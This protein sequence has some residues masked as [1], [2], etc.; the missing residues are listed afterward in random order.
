W[1][2]CGRR[3]FCDL[4]LRVLDVLVGD[5][6][7]RDRLLQP[8]IGLRRLHQRRFLGRRGGGG[9]RGWGG[10]RRRLLCRSRGA[11][12]YTDPSNSPHGA[13][14]PV[15]PYRSSSRTTSSSS[16]VDTSATSVST[17][18]SI[19][20]MSRG[21]MWNASPARSINSRRSPSCSRVNF[22]SPATT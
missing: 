1:S 6:L 22:S 15:R 19:R 17:T 8:A 3:Q 7:L 11:D 2:R 14:V 12:Q 5:R 10:R 9:R 16:G 21:G 20:W 18:A 4:P 13:F